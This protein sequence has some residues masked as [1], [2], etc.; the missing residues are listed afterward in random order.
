MNKEKLI[1]LTP[2]NEAKRDERSIN[3]NLEIL[4]VHLI[5][6]RFASDTQD[7]NWVDSIHKSI[8]NLKGELSNKTQYTKLLNSIHKILNKSID[9]AILEMKVKSNKIVR[10]A[11]IE[12]E[13]NNDQD[14]NWTNIESLINR[15]ILGNWLY[16]YYN[17]NSFQAN[18]IKNALNNHFNQFK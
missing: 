3:S 8:I 17:L 16:K 10:K 11:V 7:S 18:S 9:R 13:I 1:K 12:K 14:L 2:I 15:N 5:K 6:Y 4:Y